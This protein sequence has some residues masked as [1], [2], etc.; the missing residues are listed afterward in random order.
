LF[1]SSHW[2]PIFFR[3]PLNLPVISRRSL[4]SDNVL[5]FSFHNDTVHTI[6]YLSVW[7]CKIQRKP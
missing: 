7:N 2:F 1:A 3:F 5:L 4:N 6:T